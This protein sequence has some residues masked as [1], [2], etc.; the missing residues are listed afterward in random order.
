LLLSFDLFCHIKYKDIP[1]RKYSKTHTGANSQDGGLKFGFINVGYQVDSVEIVNMDPIMPANWHTAM[2][3][4]N[5]K[6]LCTVIFF[7]MLK[8]KIGGSDFMNQTLT[9]LENLP[10]AYTSTFSTNFR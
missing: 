5:L 7:I 3:A 2:K 6:I 8:L 9:S 4:A 10:L 1:I